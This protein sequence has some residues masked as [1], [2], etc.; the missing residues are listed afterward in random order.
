MCGGRYVELHVSAFFK[1]LLYQKETQV[2]K[3]PNRVKAYL[4]PKVTQQSKSLLVFYTLVSLEIIK[5]D[6]REKDKLA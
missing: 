4:R 6:P 2:L 1:C 3:L 5:G